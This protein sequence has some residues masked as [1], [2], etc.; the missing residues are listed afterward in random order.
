MK[1]VLSAS[2]SAGRRSSP[3]SS[4]RDGAIGRTIEIP[5]PDGA[6]EQVLAAIDGVVEDLLG[7]GAARSATAFR[8]TSTGARAWRCAPSTCRCTRCASPIAPASA[9]AFRPAS[10]TTATRPRSPSGASARGGASDLIM[11]TLGHGRRR[12]PRVDDRLYRGWAELGHVVV[13]AGRPAVPGELPRARPPRGSASGQAAD[14]RRRAVGPD[15]DARYSSSSPMRETRRRAR[16]SRR[17]AAAGRRDRL[18]RQHLRPGSRRPRRR[19]RD[20]RRR[21]RPRP[22]RIAAAPRR[23]R[24]R[25]NAADRRG[26]ARR[27][28]RAGRG[29]ARRL[30]ALDGVR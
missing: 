24:L 5:T 11:L 27:R 12:R 16:P 15:A 30:R 9:S 26:G 29:G 18:V 14:A 19:L 3:A 20:G 13:V 7:D 28:R 22:A 10:R 17:S 21:P 23:S 2:I 25:T 1:D 6:Q 8:S 4:A